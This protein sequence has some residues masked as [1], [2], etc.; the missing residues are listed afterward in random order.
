M[1]TVND[2]LEDRIRNIGPKALE[3]GVERDIFAN[4]QGAPNITNWYSSSINPAS[5]GRVYNR[6]NVGGGYS[7]TAVPNPTGAGSSP[8]RNRAITTASGH[9]LEMDDTAGNERVLIKH[10]TGSG[11]E[12]S[13]DGSMTI[14]TRNQRVVISADQTIVIEGDATIQYGGNVNMNVAGD[15]NLN[16][17]GDYNLSVGENRAENVEGSYRTTVEGNVGNTYKSGLSNTILESSTTTVLGNNTIATKGI[18]RN[19]SEGNMTLASGTIMK[20]SGKDKLFQASD[21]VNIAAGDISVFGST[22]TFGGESIVY[23]G[24]GA[25][26]SAG[27]TA[28]TFHG[29]LDGTA[30]QAVTA[31]V[32]NSQNYLE[33]ED[34]TASGYSITN[35]ATPTTALPTQTLIDNLNKTAYGASRV[36]VDIGNRL[37]NALRRT[38][39]TGGL[40]TRTPTAA[41]TRAAMRISGVRNNATFT[42]GQVSAGALSENFARTTPPPVGRISSNTNSPYRGGTRLGGNIAGG[43]SFRRTGDFRGY[44][45]IPDLPI[46]DSL[47]IQRNTK[48]IEGVPFSNFL[49]STGVAGRFNRIPT[50]NRAKY[51]RNLQL[52]AEIVKRLRDNV[53]AGYENHRLVIAEG[54]Y[55]PTAA[56]RATDGFTGSVNDFRSQGRAVVYE[57][58]DQNGNIDDEKTY[59]LAVKFKN[60]LAYQKLILDYDDYEGSLNTQIIIIMPEFDENY[61]I[62]DGNFAGDVETR[63]NNEI[64]SSSDLLEHQP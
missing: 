53:D 39:A 11:V 9:S 60:V 37:L 28:P 6:L 54:L 30:N 42:G 38:D 18:M 29:D 59:D 45:Y 23:Y 44:Q 33:S 7:G 46:L 10:N 19:T 3:E 12:L 25:T 36:F 34:G 4:P 55:V 2:D 51:A 50:A 27:I 1:T 8:G 31:D 47:T 49:G 15:Y 62:T 43:S 5:Y 40:S 14:V 16:V 32:T 56:E 48:L 20:V 41:E 64:T 57:L 13:S 17:K 26:F 35:T 58:H 22:G 52:H 24:S 21:N 63:F 61:S